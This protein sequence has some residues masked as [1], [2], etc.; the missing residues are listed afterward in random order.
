MARV[1]VDTFYVGTY[2]AVAALCR[3]R[4]VAVSDDDDLVSAETGRN[5]PAGT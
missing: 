3:P 1:D 4:P 5:S 2:A